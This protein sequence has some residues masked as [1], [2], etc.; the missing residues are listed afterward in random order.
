MARLVMRYSLFRRNYVELIELDL[1]GIAK[2]I[3]Y[4]M[5][6][7]CQDFSYRSDLYV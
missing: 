2:V 3:Y 5:Y 4:T 1:K 7:Y 6:S